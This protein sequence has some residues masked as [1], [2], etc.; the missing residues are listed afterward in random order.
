MIV[1]NIFEEI[2]IILYLFV[3]GIYVCTSYDILDLIKTKS[4]IW[5]ILVMLFGSIILIGISYIFVNK[6]K[7]GYMPQYGLL[8]VIVGITIYY[9]LF[10]QKLMKIINV[11]KRILRKIIGPITVFKKTF[12]LI[13]Q[14]NKKLNIKTLYKKKKL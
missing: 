6:L 13:K 12:Y 5:N 3:F 7:Q 1:Y 14:K 2:R 10:R 8:I 4:K 11:L 9:L